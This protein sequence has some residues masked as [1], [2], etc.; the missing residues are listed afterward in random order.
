MPDEIKSTM[1]ELNVTPAM[2]VKGERLMDIDLPDN[3]LAVM[4][5]R[6]GQFFI[7]SGK[8]KLAAGD[9]LLLLSDS[10]SDL[11]ELRRKQIAG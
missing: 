9:I 1:V 3:T 5:K 11:Q 10:A 6:Q 4:V 2:L 8:T 7:P